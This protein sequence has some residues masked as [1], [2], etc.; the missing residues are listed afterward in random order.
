LRYWQRDGRGQCSGAEKL[1]ARKM[2]ENGGI[3]PPSSAP[4]KM[5]DHH[6]RGEKLPIAPDILRRVDSFYNAK[7]SL[8]KSPTLSAAG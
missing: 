6:F 7:P 8:S 2:L 1:E 3:S 5:D 4:E